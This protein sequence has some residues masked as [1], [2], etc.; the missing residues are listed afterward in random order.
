M[1]QTVFL[2]ALLAQNG[3]CAGPD[4][5]VTSARVANVTSNAGLNHY[6]IAVTVR[7][8]GEAQ[9]ANALQF[10]DIYKSGEKKD[11]RGV[12]PLGAGRAYTFS[13]GYDRSSMAGDG[14]VTLTFRL[15]TRSGRECNTGSES[16]RLRF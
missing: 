8:R 7:N 12:P 5:A 6:A 9:P 16:F 2:A 11:A 15:D 3:T 13:Y 1:L 10:V 4:L 14:T